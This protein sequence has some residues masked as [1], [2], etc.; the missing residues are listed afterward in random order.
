M[1]GQSP[2]KY[3]GCPACQVAHADGG[4]PVLLRC[5]DCV[6]MFADDA[7][8]FHRQAAAL[9]GGQQ[10]EQAPPGVGGAA[11]V[12]DGEVRQEEEQHHQPAPLG[13]GQEVDDGDGEVE[14]HQYEEEGDNP[15]PN[16]NQN[17]GIP[18]PLI[19]GGLREED[20]LDQRMD[21]GHETE[22]EMDNVLPM[23]VDYDNVHFN[24]PEGPAENQAPVVGP[25]EYANHNP[26]EFP[27]HN[28]NN[29]WGN[30][31]GENQ[32]PVNVQANPQVGNFTNVNHPFAGSNAN[33]N[34]QFPF[35]NNLDPQVGNNQLCG[36][37]VNPGFSGNFPLYNN[38][39]VEE[40]PIY[41][42]FDLNGNP[43]PGFA[44][45]QFNHGQEPQA[46]GFYGVAAEENSDVEGSQGQNSPPASGGDGNGCLDVNDVL[47]DLGA[48][49][50]QG[51]GNNQPPAEGPGLEEFLV[52]RAAEAL[53]DVNDIL[54]GLDDDDESE[55][56][57]VDSSPASNSD[58]AAAAG[59]PVLGLF[60]LPA[61]PVPSA[62]TRSLP[63]QE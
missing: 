54:V 45:F 18:Q 5:F 19:Q 40:P 52:D 23:D 15:L 41:Q 37:S 27:I 55:S 46:Q 53:Q 1:S 51:S 14:H 30:E 10:G 29:V 49:G 2:S 57:G 32:Q 21:D 47:V 8:E 20:N 63:P 16:I 36:P 39:G 43:H 35:N 59:G 7:E 24:F 42:P 50:A 6:S 22:E 25:Q 60:L 48:E 58:A 34:P 33:F 26:P 28:N 31:V 44:G 38:P 11:E 13:M 12:G 62:P 9:L 3:G 61:A 56:E 4:E 17:G